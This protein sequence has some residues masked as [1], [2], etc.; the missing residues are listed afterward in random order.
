MN[1]DYIAIDYK[2]LSKSPSED[3]NFTTVLVHKLNRKVHFNSSKQLLQSTNIKL[4]VDNRISTPAAVKT[5]FPAVFCA[6]FAQ[7]VLF[8][9]FNTNLRIIKG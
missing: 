3:S 8:V 2:R 4:R 1:Y 5:L 9:I 7:L 6:D